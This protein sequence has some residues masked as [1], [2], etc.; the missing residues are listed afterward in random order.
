[1]EAKL[2]QSHFVLLS[3]ASLAFCFPSFLSRF[4]LFCIFFILFSLETLVLIL[5]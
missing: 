2:S 3:L 5:H 4:V 1:M